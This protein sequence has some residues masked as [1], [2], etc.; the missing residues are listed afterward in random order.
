MR[1]YLFRA[2]GAI[3]ALGCVGALGFWLAG[4]GLQL[5]RTANGAWWVA[6]AVILAFPV[7]GVV[8]GLWLLLGRPVAESG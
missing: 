4:P 7:V 1:D 6:V 3:C 8:A 2:F 5:L